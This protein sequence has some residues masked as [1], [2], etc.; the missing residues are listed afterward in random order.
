MATL[1]E[2]MAAR[3][4]EWQAKKEAEADKR[5]AEPDL[6]TRK[7][8]KA[9]QRLTLPI[10]TTTRSQRVQDA[11]DQITSG[12]FHLADLQKVLD[13][14]DGD[15]AADGYSNDASSQDDASDGSGSA[16]DYLLT[17]GYSKKNKFIVCDHCRSYGLPCDEDAVCYQCIYHG[18]A[19]V[20][21][22][23]KLSRHSKE[24]C[25]RGDCHYV[26]KDYMPTSDCFEDIAWLVLPGS[27]R[28][29]MSAGRKG[30]TY[31]CDS[32]DSETEEGEEDWNSQV[33]KETQ[34]AALDEMSA[35]VARG[36][37]SWETVVMTCECATM[38]AE[39]GEKR[40]EEK[41]ARNRRQDVDMF[42][43]LD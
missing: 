7:P 6:W 19:C 36:E 41:I 1:K 5:A 9:Q 10:A 17:E 16:A 24:D 33:V 28:G 25:P 27:L 35:V 37:A 18:V 20:H 21:H 11:F 12:G 38:E 32:Y 15:F 14:I 22:W 8:L 42:S 2:A 26:H 13:N 31:R 39:E 43:W 23:C 3:E 29:Y 30:K 34:Q 4:A 40:L